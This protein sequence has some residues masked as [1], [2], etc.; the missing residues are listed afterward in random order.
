MQPLS[1]AYNWCDRRS[2]RMGH[3]WWAGQLLL[4]LP[5]SAA[6]PCDGAGPRGDSRVSSRPGSGLTELTGWFG[7]RMPGWLEAGRC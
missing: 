5:A 1:V 2:L 7:G 6:G 3:V 4:A